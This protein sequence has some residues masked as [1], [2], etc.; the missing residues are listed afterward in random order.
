MQRPGPA[1]VTQSQDAD[2][3]TLS[4]THDSLINK[5]EDLK[6]EYAA[7]VDNSENLAKSLQLVNQEQNR[8]EN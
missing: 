8:T 4:R 5:F 2:Y 6:L 7:E 1:A 3:R